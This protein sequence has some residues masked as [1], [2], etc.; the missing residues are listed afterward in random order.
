MPMPAGQ[1]RC[2]KV[3]PPWNHSSQNA[4]SNQ[5]SVRSSEKSFWAGV[6]HDDRARITHFFLLLVGWLGLSCGF[7]DH[8]YFLQIYGPPFLR[9]SGQRRVLQKNLQLAIH[10][11]VRWWR[12]R[13]G[14][15]RRE[16]HAAAMVARRRRSVKP[17]ILARKDHFKSNNM[18]V[19]RRNACLEGFWYLITTVGRREDATEH[20]PQGI[21]LLVAGQLAKT[22]DGLA[23]TNGV[24]IGLVLLLFSH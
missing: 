22:D 7:V 11:C 9:G 14:S 10:V 6:V 5:S 23:T 1:T 4:R 12:R 24:W 13:L 19:Q 2:Q 21:L 8:L 18:C 17:I 15:P 3:T 16:E 20:S